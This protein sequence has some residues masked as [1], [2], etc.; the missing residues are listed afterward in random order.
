VVQ[1][2]GAFLLA[3]SP[4]VA[5]ATVSGSAVD[6]AGHPLPGVVIVLRGPSGSPMTVVT[7]VQGR[8]SLP[9]VADGRYTLDADLA[10]FGTIHRTIAVAGGDAPPVTL[11]MHLALNADVTVTGKH[12]FAN[13]ADAEDPAD[14]L[15][16]IAQS[17]SQG[18]ITARQID[19]RPIMRSGE[20]L[21]TIPGVVISQH[22]GEGKANQYY[23]RGFNLDHGTDFATSV[24]GMPVNMPTHAHGQGYSDL[25]FLIPELVSGVQ[26]AKGTYFAEQ[27]DFAAAGSATINYT[28]TLA[29]PMARATYGA[30]GYQRVL[31]AAA[32][33][34]SGGTLLGAVEAGHDDGPWQ[35]RSDG[36]KFNGVLRFSL[37]SASNGFSVTAMGYQARWNATD[38]IPQRAVASG[39]IDRFGLVDGTDGGSTSRYSVSGDWSRSRGGHLTRVQAFGIAYRLNLFSN[40]TYFLD[41][42]DHG[43][44]VEQADRRIVSGLRASDQHQWT[45]G[46]R[47]IK[48][49]YG[50]QLRN[51]AIG[52]V[53]LYHTER[54]R[55]LDTVGEAAVQ[56]TSAGLYAQT[57]VMWAPWLRTLTALRADGHRF[58]VNA[59]DSANSGQR[60]AGLLSAR[61]G[62]MLGPWRATEFY[63]NAGQ[64]FHSNDARGT[65]ITRDAAGNPLEPVTPLVRANTIEA[66]LRTVAIP[67]VQSTFAVWRVTLA[68]E[69]LFIGDAGTTEAGRPSTRTGIEWATYY[70]PRPWFVVD[71]DLAL[72]RSRFA[73]NL[74]E[75]N[76]IPG[77][78]QSVLSAGL[79]IDRPGGVFG[80]ARLRHFGG[81]PLIE[82]RSVTS[83]P[84]SL[85]NAEIGYKFSRGV[86]LTMDVFNLANAS[87]NDID[88]FYTSRLRGEPAAGI[89]DIHFHPALPR[90]VRLVLGVGF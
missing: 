89:D 51:D 39:A 19:A 70:A 24:A 76:A 10:N 60:T 86:R 30:N 15:V 52:N 11:I 12:T 13:L 27:G 73:D 42:P 38:Q 83:Q 49:T 90:T 28:N 44:Q 85:I 65:T 55:R 31:A 2:V 57:E 64:G 58:D 67:H 82:D 4:F 47:I 56:H 69:L 14:S 88:Y 81:R 26:Y 48:Q 61:G 7:D 45:W 41:D 35:V 23:L 50:V 87:A 74:P 84:T 16:G 22:S 25:N 62:V 68:S 6:T 75:G 9:G 1:L 33:S 71:V 59:A 80:S 72:S 32:P 36:R 18:A 3:L 40:F 54:R 63:A 21:E 8:F 77:S 66:G 43:D 46:R 34:W 37:G 79:T 20:L 29:R 17:A 5:A 53:G 78:L